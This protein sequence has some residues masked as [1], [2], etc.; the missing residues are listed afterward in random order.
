MS[1]NKS[2]GKGRRE[3][4][5]FSSRRKLEAVMRILRGEDLDTLS[6]EYGVTA[7]RLSAW[8]DVALG[9]AGAALKS[10]QA[11]PQSEE[12]RRLKE[13]IGELTMRLEIHQEME[14]VRTEHDPFRLPRSS[15]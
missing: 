9:G 3:S 6:R 4:G 14:R 15:A 5:R 1:K 8:R 13:M 10:R 2:T 12:V 11:E 7:A